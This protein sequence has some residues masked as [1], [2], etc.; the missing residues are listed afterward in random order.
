MRRQVRKAT[1]SVAHGT[2][3][4]RKL[5]LGRAASDRRVR[6]DLHAAARAIGTIADRAQPRAKRRRTGKAMLG[7]GVGVVAAGGY[8]AT[9]KLRGSRGDNDS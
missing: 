6:A 5:G 9:T 3:R 4:A 7:V 2:R 1:L 8:A